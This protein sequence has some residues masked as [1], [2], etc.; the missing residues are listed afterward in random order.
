MTRSIVREAVAVFATVKDMQAAVDELLTSNFDRADLS[1]LASADAVEQKLGYSFKST[2]NIKDEP[3]VPTAPYIEPESIAV[4]QGSAIGGF[5]YVGAIIGFAPILASGGAIGAAIIGSLAGATGGTAIGAVLASF[6]DQ[7]RADYLS[8]QLEHG[9]ILL[10]VRTSDSEHEKRAVEILS[11]HSGTDVEVLGIPDRS[12]EIAD[13][14]GEGSA[15]KVD[16]VVYKDVSIAVT[17]NGHSFAA[18]RLFSTEADAKAYIDMI[19]KEMV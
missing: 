3:D 13:Y 17:E 19:T 2:T 4:L 7:K 11:R 1:M 18:G 14:Y 5:M 6:I 15:R 9:G 10:W 8:E 16:N 12:R